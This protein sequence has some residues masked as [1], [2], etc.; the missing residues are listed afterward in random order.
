MEVPIDG[1]GLNFSTT[2]VSSQHE[3]RMSGGSA[4]CPLY[5]EVTSGLAPVVSM[6]E[7]LQPGMVYTL[8]SPPSSVFYSEE[9]IERANKLHIQPKQE[10][11]RYNIAQSLSHRDRKHK[12]RKF[13]DRFFKF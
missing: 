8:P 5:E 1:S 10:Y 3:Q 13:V 6:Q 12:K 9:V 4:A 7:S 11:M 2:D